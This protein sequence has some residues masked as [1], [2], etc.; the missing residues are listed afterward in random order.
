M[1]PSTYWSDSVLQ[2]F[3]SSYVRNLCIA[4]LE[5]ICSCEWIKSQCSRKR[6]LLNLTCSFLECIREA[7]VPWG[8]GHLLIQYWVYPNSQILPPPP[9]SLPLF[10]QPQFFTLHLLHDSAVWLTFEE[11][12]YITPPI[13]SLPPTW[14][15]STIPSYEP[16]PL[17]TPFLTSFEGIGGVCRALYSAPGFVRQAITEPADW[18]PL[19]SLLAHRGCVTQKHYNNPQIICNHNIY[20]I[21]LFTVLDNHGIR[22]TSW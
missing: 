3:L 21:N 1:C 19:R 9:S 6:Y 15:F 16:F 22:L 10:V 13:H 4:I 8:P 17:L 14:P 12:N 11:G 20:A 18:L 7:G 2:I 5:N